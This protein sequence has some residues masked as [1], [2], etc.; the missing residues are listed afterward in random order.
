MYSRV[1]TLNLSD[2]PE[3]QQNEFKH[4]YVQTSDWSVELYANLKHTLFNDNSVHLSTMLT[5]TPFMS[6]RIV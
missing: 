3:S 6:I 4:N 2:N 1:H 5:R